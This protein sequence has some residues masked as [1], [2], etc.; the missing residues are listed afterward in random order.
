MF[1]DIRSERQLHKAT[2]YNF[3]EVLLLGLNELPRIPGGPDIRDLDTLFLDAPLRGDQRSLCPTSMPH[4]Q[5]S[6]PSRCPV[7]KD[8]GRQWISTQIC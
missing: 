4:N 5:R 2:L 7:W 3:A 6:P 1:Q 8:E